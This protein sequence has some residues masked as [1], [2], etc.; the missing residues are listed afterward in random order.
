M[1]TSATTPPP[2]PT[3]ARRM[4]RDTVPML[5]LPAANHSIWTMGFGHVT[6]AYGIAAA[7]DSLSRSTR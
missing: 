3:R 7:F 1:T 4:T 2:I 6:V 5:T